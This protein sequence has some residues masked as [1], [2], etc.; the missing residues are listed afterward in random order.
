MVRAAEAYERIIPNW[1]KDMLT[2]LGIEMRAYFDLMRRIAVA[3]NNSAAKS[4]IREEMK[5]KFLA[6][7]DHIT[8]QGVAYGSCW[9]NIHHYGYSVR[10]L[11]LAYF[12]MKDV[13]REAGKLPEAEQTLRWYA[14]TN[15]VYP[16]PEGNGIDMDSFNTQTTG[17]IA[18]ILMMEDTPEKLQYLKSFSVGLI[19]VAVRLPDCLGRSRAMA[20][21]FITA[22]TT[23]LMLSA[24]W[25]EQQI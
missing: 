18:S 19:T 6:M 22:I 13:L 3:Y 23:R 12:L 10:G 15:E 16:R 8:D 9:G 2:K 5:Q 11:Y 17:R 24:V 21:F 20:A 7:Y 14:I 1:N 4:E 25:T